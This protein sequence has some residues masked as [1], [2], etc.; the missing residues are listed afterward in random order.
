VLDEMADIRN[1][2]FPED[3]D[4]NIGALFE[5]KR[6]AEIDIAARFNLPL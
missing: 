1:L 3:T 5:Q 2:Q 6:N 4:R